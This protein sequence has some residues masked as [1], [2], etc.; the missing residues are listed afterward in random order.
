MRF[1]VGEKCCDK[2]TSYL[3]QIILRVLKLLGVS[4][5]DP[6]TCEVEGERGTVNGLVQSQPGL[7]GWRSKIS[8]I[9]A[10]LLSSRP[11]H[12]MSWLG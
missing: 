11:F 5:N 4:A 12:P 3:G 2:I 9:N 7:R 1:L 8:E 10:K 6:S